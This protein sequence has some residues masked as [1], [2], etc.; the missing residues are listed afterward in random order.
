MK[1]PLISRRLV[2][3]FA[4][5]LILV[6]SVPLLQRGTQVQRECIDLNPAQQMGSPIEIVSEDLASIKNTILQTDDEKE[7]WQQK[8]AFMSPDSEWGGWLV[9]GKIL[10]HS[11]RAPYRLPA[12][13]EL[14]GFVLV[15]NAWKKPHSLRL[16]FLLD[17]QQVPFMRSGRMDYFY[18]LP[19][20]EPQEDGAFEFVFPALSRGF[21]QLAILLITDP[22]SLSTD[23]IYRNLQQHSFSEQ[24]FDLWADIELS[25]SEAPVFGTAALGQA[26]ASRFADVEVVA[27]PDPGTNEPLTSLGLK[28]G[29][30]YCVN[31]RIFN[32]KS[33]VNA[34]YT[35]AVPLLIAVFWNDRL[36]QILDYDL[37]ADA[38]DHLTLPLL[39]KAPM[40]PGS[41]QLTVA[42]LTFPG[43]SQYKAVEERTSYPHAAFSQRIFV[44][45]QR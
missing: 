22:E 35:G 29:E 18:D 3:T 26:A 16:I 41:Y 21:H 40:Q 12:H 24:R 25:P 8:N 9:E 28:T 15:R 36:E 30:G 37:L 7:L 43:W 42:V 17:S 34:P 23:R 11:S 4:V 1:I 44:E 19:D 14:R 6:T 31:L 39:I 2:L 32:E 20:L 45:V 38:P 27:S 13:Q 10:P 5:F 33:E